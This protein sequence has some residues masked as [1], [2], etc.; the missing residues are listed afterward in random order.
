MTPVN[1]V[2]TMNQGAFC[3]SCGEGDGDLNQLGPAWVQGPAKSPTAV[4]LWPSEAT[5]KPPAVNA[6][7]TMT[8]RCGGLSIHASSAALGVA[9]IQ[10][11]SRRSRP[12]SRSWCSPHP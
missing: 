6:Q 8:A 10:Y 1:S 3:Y 2:G 5:A 12:C 4:I 9:R 11:P 7:F